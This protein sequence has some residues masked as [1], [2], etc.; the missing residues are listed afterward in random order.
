MNKK[1]FTLIE[2]LAV[3]VILAIIALIA[4]PIVL[5][6]IENAKKSS[7][8]DSTYGYLD[9]LE[10]RIALSD[11]DSDKYPS[12]FE[13]NKTYNVGESELDSVSVKGTTPTSGTVTIGSNGAVETASLCINGYKIE[14]ANHKAKSS[15]SCDATYPVYKTGST[16]EVGVVYFNPVTGTKCTSS[17]AVSTTGT[18]TGCMKWYVIENSDKTKSSVDVILDHNT[19]ATVAYNS[20]G[21]NASMK[22][23]ATAMSTDTSTW[24]SGLN[25]RL[26]SADEIA[27]ITGNTTFTPSTSDSNSWFYFDTNGQTT[28]VSS[29]QKSNYAWLFDYTNGCINNGCNFNDVSTY[30]YWTKTSLIGNS[31]VYVW[32]VAQ[33]SVI[34]TDFVGNS[35]RVG[36]RPVITIEKSKLS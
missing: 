28:N 12:V 31:D 13:K 32:I 23:I 18:K 6:M 1:G 9:S 10:K 2:L 17:E 4:T 5:G 25:A 24:I 20:T 11:I 7:A 30:G 35:G 26:I 16:S 34:I 27:K 36:L 8:E 22:E 19:T 33:Y 14:Y 15:G 3:I 21:T 29:S